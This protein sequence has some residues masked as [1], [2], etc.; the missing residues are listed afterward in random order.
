MCG[1]SNKKSMRKKMP[2]KLFR[3]C[4]LSEKNLGYK[5]LILLQIKNIRYV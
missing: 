1:K 5:V 2:G 3:A 4:K